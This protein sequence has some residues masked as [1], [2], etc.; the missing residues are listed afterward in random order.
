MPDPRVT[1]FAAKMAVT[2]GSRDGMA[3]AYDA[4]H[5]Q[6]VLF[7][8]G[9]GDPSS[10]ADTWVWDGTNWTQK[11]P[12]TSPPAR[13]G[14]RMAYDTARGQIVLF[15]GRGGSDGNTFF[16]DTWVWDGTNWTQ[17]FPAASP[18]TPRFQYGFAYDAVRQQVVLFGG[19]GPNNTPIYNDTWVWDGTTWTQQLPATSPPGRTLPAMAYDEPRAQIVLFGGF[20]GSFSN[21]TW[22]WGTSF[23]AQV[24]PPINADETRSP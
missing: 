24:Q 19:Q 14:H 6:V 2:R 7:G 17:K 21:D 22:V 4:G 9:P 16:N 1:D 8:G 12:A 3:I 5:N 18:P 23:A 20:T 10:F 13:S 15:A 11:F